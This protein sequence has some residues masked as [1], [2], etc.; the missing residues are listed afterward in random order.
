M[1]NT[2]GRGPAVGLLRKAESKAT[3]ESFSLNKRHAAN[4]NGVEL[5]V[6]GEEARVRAKANV[7]TRLGEWV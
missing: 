7:S 2:L 1:E 3:T 5:T 6:S 4:D